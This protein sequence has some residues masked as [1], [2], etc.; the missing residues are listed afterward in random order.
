MK[1]VATHTRSHV[2]PMSRNEVDTSGSHHPVNDSSIPAIERQPINEMKKKLR[3][4]EIMTM[5]ASFRRVA[6]LVEMA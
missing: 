3:N 4:R 5:V 6:H 1:Q 2:I